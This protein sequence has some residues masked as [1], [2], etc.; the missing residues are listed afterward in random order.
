MAKNEIAKNVNRPPAKADQK[1]ITT[2]VMSNIMNK[3]NNGEI[4]FP[5]NYAVQNAVAS[6]ALKI[7]ET[8]DRDD[9]PALEVCT[10]DSVASAILGMVVQGLNPDR[11]QCY[12]IVYGNKLVM[13]RSYLGT[14]AITK[15]IPSVKDVK[16]Y[17]V[18][19]DDSF[20]LGFDLVTGRQYVKE[21]SPGTKRDPKDLIGAF[22]VIIGEKEILHTEW[23]TM[24]QI[25]KAWGMGN[26][27]GNSPAHKDFPDEMAKKSV[28]NRAC[29]AYAS[30]A[31]DAGYVT[32]MFNKH[33]DDQIEAEI[34][35]NANQELIGVPE[36]E[37]M[38]VDTETGEILEEP[39]ED[40][41]PFKDPPF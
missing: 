29:K 37:Y 36:A 14:V 10:R 39:K 11:D 9:R 28:I 34:E 23:M 30:T 32:E 41:D 16:G 4:Q 24:E 27:K 26:A 2:Q 22:A 40:D 6:A 31:D 19:K 21:Y 17:A 15:R 12:F 18:Y 5:P 25:R 35:A 38:S 20:E 1:Y 3:W 8:K 7:S 33:S 13:Q